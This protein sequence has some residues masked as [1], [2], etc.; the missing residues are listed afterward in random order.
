M[1]LHSGLGAGLSTLP[2]GGAIRWYYVRPRFR[3]FLENL[4]ITEEQA[5]DGETK[6]R[7]VVSCLN[8]GYWNSSDDSMTPNSDRLLGE[9]YPGSPA[10]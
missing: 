1:N 4:K 2:L 10:A 6:H 3:A 7:G 5:N 9:V 8:R